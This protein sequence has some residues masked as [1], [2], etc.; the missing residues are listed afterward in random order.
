ML[1]FI[2]YLELLSPGVRGSQSPWKAET[3]GTVDRREMRKMRPGGVGAEGRGRGNDLVK[4]PWSLSD[5]VVFTSS[6]KADPELREVS[7]TLH[8][9]L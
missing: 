7:L 1:C 5:K 6:G 9:R 3:E 8:S 4:G 2:L